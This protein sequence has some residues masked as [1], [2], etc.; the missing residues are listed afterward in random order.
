MSLNKI[1][2]GVYSAGR[3]PNA[4][5]KA[6][7]WRDSELL[8]TDWIAPTTDHPQHADYLVYRQA[9]RE[10]PETLDFPDTKPEL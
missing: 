10:W 5:E 8:A 3:L 7:I 4:E 1:S 2:D 6:K 9:L